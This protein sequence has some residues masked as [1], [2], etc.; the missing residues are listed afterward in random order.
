MALTEKILPDSPPPEL[1]YRHQ[2]RPLASIRAFWGARALTWALAERDIRARY[3]Q[4]FLGVSWSVITPLIMMVAFNVF[5]KRVAK[6]DTGDIPYPIFSY[7]GLLAWQFFSGSISS[8]GY[9]FITDSQLLNKIACP[10]EVFPIADIVGAGVDMLISTVV[11][12]LLFI[13]FGFAPQP[14]S[15]WVPVLLL[16]MVVFTVGLVLLICGFFVYVRDMK[17]IVPIMLQLGLFATPVAWGLESIP[18]AWRGAYCAVNPLG[19]VIDGLRR[20]VL[21]GTGPQMDLVVYASI[22]SVVY[23][24]VGYLTLKKLEVGFA[25][26]A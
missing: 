17:Q 14:E 5:F 23:L 4:A 10:R 22:S 8:G 13:V 3:K 15:Y 9:A 12:G 6:I 25:D 20:T 2:S 7:V 1:R 24:V 18:A 26:V 11:L 21:Y 19:L 16:I